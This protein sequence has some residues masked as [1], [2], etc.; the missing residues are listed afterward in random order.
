MCGFIE[1]L[2]VHI[3]QAAHRENENSEIVLYCIH[4]R[5]KSQTLS[6]YL[7]V[8][9]LSAIALYIELVIRM[10]VIACRLGANKTYQQD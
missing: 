1:V 7:F 3:L 9:R 5:D 2:L 8:K 10:F 4:R 6:A